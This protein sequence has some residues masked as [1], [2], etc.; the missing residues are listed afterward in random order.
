MKQ[1]DFKV[2]VA[3]CTFN[4]EAFVEAQ[5]ESILTQTR[6]PDEIV[7]CDD[8]STDVTVDAATRIAGKYPDKIR[9][10][11]NEQRLG[12]CRNFES[13]VRLATGDL[14][15]LSDQDDVWFPDK[16]ES[17]L[18]VFADNPGVVLV[19][20]D[21]VV[22][23][24]DLQP[25]GTVFERRKDADLRKPPTLQQLSRGLAFNGPMMAFRSLLK[26][27]VV[28][29]APLSLHWGHDHWIAFIAYAV[30]EI[31][32]IDRPLVYYRRHET[33]SGG[34]AELDG[35]LLHQ[36]RVVKK[37]YAGAKEYG[38]RRRAWEDMV[39]RLHE[40]KNSGLPLSNPAKL[41]DL[42]EASEMC[43]QFAKDRQM[44]KTRGRW[45]RAPGVLRLL[46]TGGY[47]RYARGLKSFV[48]DVVLP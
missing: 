38:E 20:S 42:L 48:Q 13:A 11:R 32:V 6:L 19:Y 22:T 12:Y 35:G 31:G 2:S 44:Y 17:M 24:R 9:I 18:R 47:H 5:L 23:D 25:T 26:P 36:W 7:L 16:V 30:G 41:H 28:P 15:F 43:L 10:I 27:F 46:F 4:G 34:D 8:G 3:M 39:A 29:F 40:L 33:N 1:N 21:A 14:I 45:G 37:K